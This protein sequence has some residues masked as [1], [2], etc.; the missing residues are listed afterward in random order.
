[1]RETG[2]GQAEREGG[3]RERARPHRYDL[4]WL[5][6][7]L[8][9]ARFQFH[10]VRSKFFPSHCQ[11]L[12]LSPPAFINYAAA[13]KHKQKCSQRGAQCAGERGGRGGVVEGVGATVGGTM[14]FV[15]DFI[16]VDLNNFLNAFLDDAHNSP[17][18]LTP[19]TLS[20]SRVLCLSLSIALLVG[21]RL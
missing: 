6:F 18:P 15:F 1:M 4:L 2:R 17:L 16:K 14:E 8:F 11:P 21:F 7:Y 3:L 13:S 5:G 9:Y 12:R 20:P 10:F 19:L